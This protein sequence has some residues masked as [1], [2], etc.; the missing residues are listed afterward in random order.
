SLWKTALGATAGFAAAALAGTGIAALLASSRLVRRALGPYTVFF[1]TV[2][3]VAIA[4][5]LVLW[6]GAGLR[7]VAACAFIVSVFPVIANTTAG[8]LGTDAGLLDLFRLYGATPVET[9]TMLRFPHALPQWFTGLRIAA[10][11]S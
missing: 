8:L 6:F 7:S 2:P 10:G 11:L 4:P 1:Q 5:L 3:V 9:M